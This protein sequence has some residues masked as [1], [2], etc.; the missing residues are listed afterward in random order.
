LRA[1]AGVSEKATELLAS[2]LD[3]MVS[4]VPG[5]LGFPSDVA[6]SGY[7]PGDIRTTSEELKVV[8]SV[9]REHGIGEENTRVRKSDAGETETFDVLL[10]SVETD[11]EPRPLG[12]D[13]HVRLV[14]GDHSS[15]LQRVCDCLAEA[16]KF[17]ENPAQE[18]YIEEYRQ[19]FL[20]GD[21][22]MHKESQRTWVKDR[23]PA[24]E[25]AFGFVE[26]YRDPY[27][28]RA[29]FEGIV[30]VVDAQATRELTT[31]VG[32]SEDFICTLPW[33]DGHQGSGGRNG[34]FEK[35]LPELPDFTAIHGKCL[36]CYSKHCI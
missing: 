25:V 35:D 22:E 7:Y 2:C 15:P 1:I 8:S 16:K 14:R 13:P 5:S 10:A 32:S 21:L 27:G 17:V 19:H 12:T 34:P 18:K 11:P 36:G 33:V 23:K 9:M 20:T 3:A 28:T 26:P 6:Q 29:E 30:A 24:V 4:P 31:L